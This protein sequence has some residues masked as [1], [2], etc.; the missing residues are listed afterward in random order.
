MDDSLALQSHVNGARSLLDVGS[1]GGFPGLPLALLN[2]QTEVTL[3]ERNQRKCSFLRHVAMKLEM[4]NVQILDADLKDI[5]DE[6]PLFDVITAR[7][8]SQPA[9]VW[10]WCRDLLAADGSLLLQLAERLETIAS[11]A[12]LESQ[13]SSGIGWI[14]IVRRESA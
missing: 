8:V 5:K 10:A 4:P 3:I 13:R 14:H 6:L 7:A 1:G 11:D 12:A 9:T 2:P